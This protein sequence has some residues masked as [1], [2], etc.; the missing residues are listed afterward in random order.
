MPALGQAH[1]E[2]TGDFQ[3]ERR[4][5][6][7]LLAQ[8]LDLFVQLAPVK[9]AGALPDA[10]H[11]QGGHE[12]SLVPHVG[13]GPDED[14]VGKIGVAGYVVEDLGNNFVPGHDSLGR[15]NEMHQ[16]PSFPAPAP[17]PL[18]GRQIQPGQ[19][20]L[21]GARGRSRPS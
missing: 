6:K 1:G 10:V 11:H 20:S 7:D 19:A 3:A 4:L 8:A 21:R 14:L 16:Q 5:E 17:A 9:V 13:I 18:S 2:L 12:V 15:A